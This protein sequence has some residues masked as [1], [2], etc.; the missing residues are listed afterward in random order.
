M[1]HRNLIRAGELI[2]RGSI[3]EATELI[4]STGITTA[5]EATDR[6]LVLAYA[7]MRLLHWDRALGRL[8]EAAERDPLN[9]LPHYQAGMCHYEKGDF[10]AAQAAHRRA[11]TIS[12]GFA[13][14]WLKLGGAL[15]PQQHW[16]EAL[17]CYERAIGLDPK[18]PELRLGYG[19]MLYL[20]QDDVAC[21]HQYRTAK[22]ANPGSHEADIMLGMTLLRQGKWAE[23]WRRF[24]QRYRL[25]PHGAA[26]DHV[27][28]EPWHGRPEGLIGKDVLLYSEQGFGDTIQ[29]ARYIPLVQRLAGSVTVVTW[30]SL[31]RLIESL[32]HAPPTVITFHEISG[33]VIDPGQPDCPYD[34]TTSLMALPEVFGT[35]TTDCA[36]PYIYKVQPKYT[37]AKLGLC[38]QGGSRPEDPLAHADDERRSVPTDVI[39][40][41]TDIVPYVCL[42]EDQ[43]KP[44]GVTD[45]YGTAEIIQGLE[46]IVTVDTAVAHLAASLGKETW[47]LTR[48]GGCWRWMQHR[49]DTPWY[50]TMRLYRQELISDWRPTIR[51]VAADL[52]AWAAGN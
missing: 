29:F 17:A 31:K 34:I 48:Y 44:W 37:G 50:P 13:K 18:D 32:D 43:L 7:D 14:A 9:P 45:W 10:G 25:R 52:T 46:L 12:P 51:R 19:T 33:G 2:A 1:T 35:T 27:G 4:E 22:A 11:I 8:A 24:R 36:A 42:H 30:P 26:W 21:E 38:W 47:L 20:M 5:G 39:A 16:A 49:L 15:L 23:G 6:L 3:T 41:L 40:P 28:H